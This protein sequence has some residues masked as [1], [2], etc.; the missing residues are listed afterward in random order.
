MKMLLEIEV[1]D[2]P[3]IAPNLRGAFTRTVSDWL[4]LELGGEA[5]VALL[6]VP[7]LTT[8][9]PENKALPLLLRVMAGSEHS[10]E[11][12][13]DIILNAAALEIEARRAQVPVQ[14][15][16]YAIH[17]LFDETVKIEKRQ[18]GDDG[19]GN[20]SMEGYALVGL[21]DFCE[22]VA[23]LLQSKEPKR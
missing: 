22:K 10:K 2:H 16:A 15:D 20:Y 7:D 23:V 12:R 18:Y 21:K 11:F 13:F 4:C 17:K 1:Q 9:P 3:G 6:D 14:A 19:Y 5:R 8:D